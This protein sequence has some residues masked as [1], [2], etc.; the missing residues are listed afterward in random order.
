MLAFF[1]F[2]K[3]HKYIVLLEI[4]GIRIGIF[5]ELYNTS[6]ACKIEC[7][8]SCFLFFVIT[9]AVSL[10]NILLLNNIHYE[11]QMHQL[12]AYLKT[13]RCY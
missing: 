9:I 10:L 7:K 11:T 3:K 8:I 2:K 12:K 5:F 6:I 13:L 1:V 4:K